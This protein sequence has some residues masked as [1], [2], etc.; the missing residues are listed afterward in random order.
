MKEKNLTLP[1]N[2]EVF[3]PF[4]SICAIPLAMGMGGDSRQCRRRS[5][6]MWDLRRRFSMFVVFIFTTY[7]I[8]D[9]F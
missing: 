7:I 1:L 5:R 6:P 4:Q 3:D 9:Y 2:P 8:V